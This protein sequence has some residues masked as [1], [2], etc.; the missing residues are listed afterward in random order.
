MSERYAVLKLGNQLIVQA[1]QTETGEARVL[2][3]IDLGEFAS[4]PPGWFTDRTFQRE[5]QDFRTEIYRGRQPSRDD[6]RRIH[7]AAENMNSGQPVPG[8]AFLSVLAD[9][10]GMSS[11][12]LYWLM[13]HGENLGL[14]DLGFMKGKRGIHLLKK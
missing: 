5:I 13:A 4:T 11:V 10:R 3:T 9:C 8:I 14:W 1:I 6:L 12:Y 2:S 7:K